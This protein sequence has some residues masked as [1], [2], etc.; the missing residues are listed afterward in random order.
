MRSSIL[1]FSP[2]LLKEEDEGG[3]KRGGV[4]GVGRRVLATYVFFLFLF[5]LLLFGIDGAKASDGSD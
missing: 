1:S 2:E 4:W 5:S 3:K